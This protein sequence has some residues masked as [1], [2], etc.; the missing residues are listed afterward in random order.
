MGIAT[1]KCFNYHKKCREFKAKIR[2]LEEE[3]KEVKRE[4]EQEAR[5]YEQKVAVFASKEAEW[6]R[7][8]KKHKEEVTKIRKKLKEEED[9]MRRLEEVAA[10]RGDKEWYQISTGYLVEHMKEEQA[11]MEEAVEKW[12]HLYLAIKTELDD[13]I[14]RTRQGEGFC[15]GV[16]EGMIEE[17][18]RE[19]K[20]KEETLETLRSRISAMEQEGTKRDREIDILRQSLRILGNTKRNR[21]RKNPP[22]GLRLESG[23]EMQSATCMGSLNPQ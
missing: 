8:R 14:Q 20:A 2:V 5:V 16:K 9:R 15:W 3:M 17:L 4:R 18:H 12:K 11:R 21:I 10:S 1:S 22:R 19:L 7:E 13:L 23:R 6:K